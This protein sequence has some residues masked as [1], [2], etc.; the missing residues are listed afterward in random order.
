MLK[1]SIKDVWKEAWNSP[2][3]RLRLI[4]IIVLIPVFTLSLPYFFTYVEA[5]KG[6]VLNDWLL[7]QIPARNVSVLIFAV[8]WGMMLLLFYRSLRSPSIFITYMLSLAVVTITR[9]ICIAVFKLEPPIGLIPI[10]DP[11]TGVF[12][13]EAPI[14]KDL[15]FSGH[16]ATVMLIFLCLEKKTD[17]LI[18]LAAVIAI[19]C[20]LLIQHIHYTIDVV[21]APPMVYGGYRLMRY[22]LYKR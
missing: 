16:T 15:F 18:G 8:I 9:I 12:Y 7:A 13:G 19:M 3:T 10:V 20:L 22:F 11:L 6:V 17:R 1:P 5:R 4:V 14:T 2:V 21:A